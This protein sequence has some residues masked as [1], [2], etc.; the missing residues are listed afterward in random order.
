MARNNPVTLM[1]IDLTTGPSRPSA[2]ALLDASG[3]LVSLRKLTT[4]EEIV[5]LVREHRPAVVA[6]DSPLG[7]PKGMDCLE[8]SCDCESVHSFKGRAGERD[9]ISLGINLYVTTKRSFIKPMIYRAIALARE[10]RDLGADVIEVYPFA[11]KVRLFGR[12]IPPKNT[13]E[14]RRFLRSRLDGLIR[15]LSLVRQRLDHDHLDALV[16]AYTAWLYGQGKTEG[17]GLEEEVP[18]VLPVASD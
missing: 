16:A 2:C 8:E 13:A 12:P 14:G 18:I 7:L 11:S 9:L 5:D 6:I 1:G 17:I 4:D 15:G 3:A 10:M